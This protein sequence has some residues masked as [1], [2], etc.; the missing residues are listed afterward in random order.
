MNLDDFL[1]VN[2][3]HYRECVDVVEKDFVAKNLNGK[4]RYHHLKFNGNGVPMVEA[5]AEVLYDYIIDY[6]LSAKSRTSPLTTV[7]ST[8]LTKEARKLFRRPIVTEDDPDETGEAGEAL[9]FFL[10]ESVLKAPQMV[11]KMELKTNHKDEVKGSDGIH[12]GW[13]ESEKIVDFYFGESKLYKD[14]NS[15]ISAVIKSVNSFHDNEMYKHELIMVT[16]YF[17]YANE[18]IQEEISELIQ[19]G[20]P[21]PNAR[22]NHACLVGYDWKKYGD[23]SKEKLH[24]DFISCLMLD[25]EK[26]V[27]SLD[28]KFEKFEKKH[29]RF[30]FFF[31][32]FPSVTD[33]RNSFN[34][35]LS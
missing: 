4:V 30:E 21:G 2:E 27:S 3:K 7:Q 18:K 6:C 28:S 31:L 9:L 24:E 25:A 22:L 1:T 19:R 23:L 32:P 8:R 29:L 17:K 35:A 12:A 16:K 20:E 33:F 26:I 13:S 10:I 15:A 34:A 11:A 5:L 14:V